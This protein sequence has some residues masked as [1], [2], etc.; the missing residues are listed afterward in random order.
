MKTALRI[1]APSL[2]ATCLALAGCSEQ[3]EEDA[4]RAVVGAAD[5]A[6]DNAEAIVGELREG[7]ID[8]ADELSDGAAEV[9]DDLAADEAESTGDGQLDGSE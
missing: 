4:T 1:F 2:V 8:V 6:A 5:D 9:R 3:T 7:A